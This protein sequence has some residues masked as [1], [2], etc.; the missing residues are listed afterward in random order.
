MKGENLEAVALDGYSRTVY[1]V[2][3][4][5][6]APARPRSVFFL[7]VRGLSSALSASL[8]VLLGRA[9]FE[10]RGSQVVPTD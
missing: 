6:G 7:I 3:Y 5:R 1:T 4:V 10:V 8:R 9:T 2:R